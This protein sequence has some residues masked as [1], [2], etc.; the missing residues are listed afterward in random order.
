VNFREKRH[1]MES[2][3]P[4]QRTD[5]DNLM[6]HILQ[7]VIIQSQNEMSRRPALDDLV[8]TIE[9][10][11][12][13]YHYEM[14]DF[15]VQWCKHVRESQE[16]II[17]TQD[18]DQAKALETMLNKADA[19][20]HKQVKNGEQVDIEEWTR[21]HMNNNDA[22]LVKKWSDH[23]HYVSTMHKLS[24][25]FKTAGNRATKSLLDLDIMYK[26]R[27]TQSQ[28]EKVRL[29]TAQPNPRVDSDPV[30]CSVCM[31]ERADSTIKRACTEKCV[32]HECKC[33]PTVCVS[34]LV[35][36]RITA[37]TNNN[38]S[39]TQFSDN[40]KS[41]KCPTCNAEFCFTDIYPVEITNTSSTK[42][43]S[44]KRKASE[45]SKV[46]DANPKKVVKNE[47]CE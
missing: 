1:E 5:V 6:D 43:Q 24:H 16:R 17:E 22:E 36:H 28:V 33:P 14:R 7:F 35:R 19:M 27:A 45:S 31:D 47:N 10:Q 42:R 30:I 3:S 40:S 38:G 11:Q 4:L 39:C 12:D 46:I 23:F 44:R 32:G 20:I 18:D 21:E 37:M 15:I 9:N 8:R 29:R 25:L 34:C 26:N 2:N 41:V 13:R